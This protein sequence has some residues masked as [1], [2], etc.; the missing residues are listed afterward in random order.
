MRVRRKSLADILMAARTQ[1]VGVGTK[2]RIALD[3]CLMRVDVAAH[4]SDAAFEVTLA[5]PQSQC[6]IGEAPRAAIRPV[7][8]VA[9][10]LQVVF[11]HRQEIVVVVGAR[12]VSLHV[13]IAE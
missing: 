9:G 3:F 6:V 13:D 2:L 12:R 5:L 8:R 7:S 4:A 10:I 1:R 11:E